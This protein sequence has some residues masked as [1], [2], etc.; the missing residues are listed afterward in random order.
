MRE[1]GGTLSL[2]SAPTGTP[3][4]LSWGTFT[5]PPTTLFYIDVWTHGELGW[6]LGANF[7]YATLRDSFSPGIWLFFGGSRM[8]DGD[9]QVKTISWLVKTHPPWFF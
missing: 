2:I 9:P 8:W 6:G 5:T 1:L 3:R 4:G 7:E